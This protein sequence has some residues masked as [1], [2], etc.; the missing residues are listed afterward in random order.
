MEIQQLDF[1]GPPTILKPLVY[2][3]PQKSVFNSSDSFSHPSRSGNPFSRVYDFKQFVSISPRSICIYSKNI[4]PDTRDYTD[5]WISLGCSINAD[6]SVDKSTMIAPIPKDKR[7]NGLISKKAN[8][9]VNKCIDWMVLLSNGQGQQVTQG[10]YSYDFKLNFITI[11]LPSKQRHSD[12]FIKKNILAPFINNLR[13]KSFGINPKNHKNIYSKYYFWRAETQANGNIHFH[14]ITDVYY[15]WQQL[16]IDWNKYLEKYGYVSEFEKLHNHR[17]PNSTD[18][19][20]L[21]RIKNIGRYLSKYCGKNSKGYQ[22]LSD[23]NHIRNCR[24]YP[25][26]TSF[27]WKL[28]KVNAK[29]FRPVFG[30]LWGCSENLSRLKTSKFSFTGKL[31]NEILKYKS[32]F[33]KKVIMRDFVTIIDIDLTKLV[34]LDMPFTRATM[35]S[36]V[37]S[38]LKPPPKN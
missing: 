15:P 2:C 5:K 32:M 19:H 8:K 27:T 23:S 4:A 22:I 25:L 9:Q 31:E 37:A 12:S 21:L 35:R 33:P 16:K 1:F 6:G 14:L 20:S 38:R 28:P 17:F 24:N 18:V 34:E 7:N 11:T 36:F 10:N 29:F 13:Q 3:K 30:R 26:F